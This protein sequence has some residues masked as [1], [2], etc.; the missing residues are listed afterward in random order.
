GS[1]AEAAEATSSASRVRTRRRS[2]IGADVERELGTE[3]IVVPAVCDDKCGVATRLERRELHVGAGAA[4]RVGA[5]PTALEASEA[6]AGGVEELDPDGRL[7]RA[8]AL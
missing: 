1:R 7:D 5:A 2:S 3:D 6:A 4:A 8:F